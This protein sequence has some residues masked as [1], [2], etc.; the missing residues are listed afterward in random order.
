MRIIVFFDDVLAH[1]RPT[2]LWLDVVGSKVS[3]AQ[4]DESPFLVTE[5][6]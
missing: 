5:A 2:V 1:E 4:N 6:T 3:T